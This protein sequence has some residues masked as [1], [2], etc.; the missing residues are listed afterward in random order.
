MIHRTLCAPLL[1]LAACVEPAPPVEPQVTSHVARHELLLPTAS[2][3]DVLFVI[4]SSPAIAGHRAHLD[5]QLPALADALLD[6]PRAP[7]LHL[8]VISADVGA[9]GVSGCTATGDGGQMN[10]RGQPITGTFITDAPLSTGTRV[11]NYTGSIGE[12]FR[13]YANVGAQGCSV[14][15]PFD[16]V[17][18]AL[19]PATNPGFFRPDAYFAVVFVTATDDA[20]EVD[21]ASFAKELKSPFADPYRVI[22]SVIAGPATGASS[23]GATSAPRLHALAASFPNRSG[24]GSICEADLTPAIAIIPQLYKSVLA[25]QCWEE[26]PLDVDP[27]TPGDQLDCTAALYNATTGTGVILAPCGPAPTSL[28][29]R[30]EDEQACDFSPGSGLTTRLE[31]R[32]VSLPRETR[33][34]V[35]CVVAGPS[36]EN[37]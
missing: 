21:V 35:E 11:R 36:D 34:W 4:D 32:A 27:S 2:K 18:R 3:I 10:Q 15:R 31:P 13:G 8:G 17:R 33:G 14:S 29:F 20:S 24:V 25:I 26:T 5:E 16:A 1:L 30:I 28:C 6:A 9:V 22:V 19:D 12:V 23:C 7:D 37:L